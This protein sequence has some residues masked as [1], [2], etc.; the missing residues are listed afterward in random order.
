MLGST[1]MMPPAVVLALAAVATLAALGV[2]GA[3]AVRLVASRQP[4][5][6]A[7]H[8]GRVRD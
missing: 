8:S 7:A 1:A 5:P 4:A 2:G 6:R 3:L